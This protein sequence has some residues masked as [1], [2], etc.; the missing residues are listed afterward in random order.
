[1]GKVVAVKGFEVRMDARLFAFVVKGEV[2]LVRGR[3]MVGEEGRRVF[4][5][6]FLSRV[7][8]GT[9]RSLLKILVVDSTL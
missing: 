3:V 4:L 5:G 1:M 9:R 7:A 6:C 8:L 2:Y